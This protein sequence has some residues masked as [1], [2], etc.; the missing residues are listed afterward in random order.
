[1]QHHPQKDTMGSPEQR[2]EL[3]S[4]TDCGHS[5][6]AAPQVFVPDKVMSLS[7]PQRER[8]RNNEAPKGQSGIEKKRNKQQNKTE[9][10]P[11]KKD[12]GEESASGGIAGGNTVTRDFW[13]GGGS[14]RAEREQLSPEKR[15]R[16]G[17]GISEEGTAGKDGVGEI[18]V[19]FVLGCA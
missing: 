12:I 8:A 9:E 15:E 19:A 16:I 4:R 3:T 7:L 5:P 14:A 6:G 17:K 1:M 11:S 2:D 10:A 13:S 18:N